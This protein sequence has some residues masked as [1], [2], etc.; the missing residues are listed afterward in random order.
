ME[1]VVFIVDPWRSSCKIVNLEPERNVMLF[2][3]PVGTV[4]KSGV[5]NG[6]VRIWDRLE[7]GAK[8]SNI[9]QHT[10]T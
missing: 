4:G 8:Y 9:L 10:A 7:A 5:W 1:P 2:V 3:Q 6:I